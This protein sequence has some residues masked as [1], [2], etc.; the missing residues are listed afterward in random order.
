MGLCL[1]ERDAQSFLSVRVRRERVAPGKKNKK[2]GETVQNKKTEQKFELR[3]V[4]SV[5]SHGAE[6]QGGGERGSPI[7]F[8]VFKVYAAL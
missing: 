4:S 5:A 1:S 7:S 6:E 3:L 2:E 8:F